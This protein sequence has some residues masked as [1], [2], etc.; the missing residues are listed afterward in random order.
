MKGII[1]IIL[2][3]QGSAVMREFVFKIRRRLVTH[4]LMYL[5]NAPTPLIYDEGKNCGDVHCTT[6]VYA[7]EYHCEDVDFCISA[8]DSNKVEEKHSFW[9]EPEPE[10]REE[11]KEN[12]LIIKLKTE[13]HEYCQMT[14]QLCT[15]SATLINN[16]LLHE[17]LLTTKFDKRR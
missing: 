14:S 7:E 11:D 9:K 17:V 13:M 12:V 6:N 5:Q 16:I 3:V 10:Q 4:N 8:I 15:K 1:I 2:T